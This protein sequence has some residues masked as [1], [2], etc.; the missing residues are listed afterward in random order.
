MTRIKGGKLH[1]KRRHGILKHTKGYRWGRKSSI[2]VAKV[3]KM[4]AGQHAFAG[5]RTKKR[6]ARQLWNVRINAA[7]RELDM[8]Y[9]K[10]IGLL[11]KNNVALDRKILS[12]L[13]IQY[14]DLFKTVVSNLK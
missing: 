4:K 7:L 1:T 14:P 12:T 11:K 3:A 13:A 5:R 8:S 10:V 2:K 6:A 9:S